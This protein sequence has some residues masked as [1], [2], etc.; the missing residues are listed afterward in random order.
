MLSLICTLVG[1]IRLRLADCIGSVWKIVRKSFCS[2]RFLFFVPV[3][4][5]LT[6]IFS[7]RNSLDCFILKEVLLRFQFL[8]INL[9]G[10]VI[11]VFSYNYIPAG[12]ILYGH[13]DAI[14]MCT[15]KS[16]RLNEFLISLDDLD[17]TSFDCFSY[18][19]FSQVYDHTILTNSESS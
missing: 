14:E 2:V 18:L 13:H 3:D 6:Y 9:I 16:F 10:L 7:G 19:V 8:P 15:A 11:Q 1:F 4:C 12:Y 5:D 17:S